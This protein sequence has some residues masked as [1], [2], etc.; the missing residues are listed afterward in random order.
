MVR[1]FLK[2][3]YTKSACPE[4]VATNITNWFDGFQVFGRS[5]IIHQA[6]VWQNYKDDQLYQINMNQ[7][8]PP[9]RK[10]FFTLNF[11]RTYADC[12][13]TTDSLLKSD[14]MAF[15]PGIPKTLGLP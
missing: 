7:N 3:R 11:L 12:I 15:H 6:T 13:I 9:C 1:L 4:I 5:K 2:N 10:T 14:P 8:T